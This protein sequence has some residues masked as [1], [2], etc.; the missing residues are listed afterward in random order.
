MLQHATGNPATMKQWSPKEFI[1]ALEQNPLL[2]F[3]G[4]GTDAIICTDS[5]LTGERG[6]DVHFDIQADLQQHGI[7]DHGVLEG[8][9]E[10]MAFYDFNLKIHERGHSTNSI[11][12]ISRQRTAR[13]PI[14]LG[15][16]ALLRWYAK[17]Q[18]DDIIRAG[19]G[20]GNLSGIATVNQYHPSATRRF[21]GGQNAASTVIHGVDDSIND[22]GND[23][24]TDYLDYMFGP[25]VIDYC[26]LWARMAEPAFR[27]VMVKGKEYYVMLISPYQM[28]S[29]R[30]NTD[31]KEAQRYANIRGEDNP[32][33]SGAEGVWNGVVIHTY[34]KMPYRKAAGY[35]DNAAEVVHANVPANAGVA[36]GLFLGA[37]AI[38]LGWGS[39][40]RWYRDSADYADRLPVIGMDVIYGVAK[41]QFGSYNDTSGV[42]TQQTD[43]ACMTVDTCVESSPAA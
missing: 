21:V 34:S 24:A 39:K 1:W 3:M 40:M 15:K 25:A 23:D 10:D 29:L 11:S 43:F 26:A 13:D 36:R 38:C 33:F 12:R 2:K 17:E 4:P 37:Q 35:F 20:M 32:I 19:C 9:G 7:G 6:D 41:T 8:N 31:W 42:T 18:A 30:Q 27:P 14:K 28:F 16:K 22:L 5:S